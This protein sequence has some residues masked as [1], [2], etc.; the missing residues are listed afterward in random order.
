[1]VLARRVATGDRHPK[2]G[3]HVLIGVGTQI[4][5][6]ITVGDRAKIGAGSVVLWPIPT[7]LDADRVQALA[8]G[9]LRTLGMS[10]KASRRFKSILNRL[11]ASLFNLVI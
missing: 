2:I 6:N 1:M 5:R 7:R 10:K 11:G 4:L 3:K 9:D 8:E